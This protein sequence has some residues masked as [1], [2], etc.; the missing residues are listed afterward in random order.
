MPITHE[1]LSTLTVSDFKEYF[2]TVFD[3][4]EDTQIQNAYLEANY[5][6]NTALFYD[7]DDLKI[8]FMYLA[9]HC[10]AVALRMTGQNSVG[11]Q[12]ISGS[13]VNGVSISYAIPDAV[14]QKPQFSGLN[15]TQYGQRYLTIIYPRLVGN[16]GCVQ[17]TTMP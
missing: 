14:A 15:L 6:I 13:G 9:A 5:Q 1:Y 8:G 11:E 17:G 10:L 16:V 4:A 7:N 12:V 3:S 2:P